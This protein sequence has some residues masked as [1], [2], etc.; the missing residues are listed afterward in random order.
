[1]RHA[2]ERALGLAAVVLTAAF[3]WAVA[4]GG[5]WAPGAGSPTKAGTGYFHGGKASPPVVEDAACGS[6]GCHA[7]T[8]HAKD[9]T[10][11]P[12]RNMHGR[13]VGCL[14]CHG[15]DSRGTWIVAPPAAASTPGAGD[16][17][18]LRK[19]WTI[20]TAAPAVGRDK[21]HTVL[22]VALSCRACHSGEGSREISAKGGKELPGGF[23]DPVALRMIEKGAKQWIPDTMQ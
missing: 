6:A 12:F 17:G 19:R 18:L 15:K 3:L 4:G 11:A 13:F 16:D 5:P 20:A 10:Y 8:P 7:G 23:D 2:A 22:G 1:M 21:A 14:V 9:R